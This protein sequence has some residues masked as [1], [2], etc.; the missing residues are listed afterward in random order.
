MHTFANIALL[1]FYAGVKHDD[2]LEAMK[3]LFE[4][5][6]AT[7]KISIFEIKSPE[8]AD[9]VIA[10]KIKAS[11]MLK[12]LSL[13]KRIITYL[14]LAEPAVLAVKNGV[15]KDFEINEKDG[16]FVITTNEGEVV[17]MH[18]IYRETVS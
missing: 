18:Q 10:I 13:Q 16:S 5:S 17:Q 4:G 2:L 6:D 1:H 3:E 8:T 9:M 7:H 11:S 15:W 12:V 14:M